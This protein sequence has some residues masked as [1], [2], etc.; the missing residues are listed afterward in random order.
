M[1]IDLYF[2]YITAYTEGEYCYHQYDGYEYCDECCGSRNREYCCE[3]TSWVVGVAVGVTLGGLFLI[4]FVVVVVCICI[5]QKG[6]TGRVIQ[7]SYVGQP[8]MSK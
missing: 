1:L 8:A 2:M 4:G 7:P 6:K 3:D 5:K